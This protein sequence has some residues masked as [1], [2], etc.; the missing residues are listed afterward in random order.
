MHIPPRRAVFPSPHAFS[1][2]AVTDEDLALL[3]ARADRLNADVLKE[4]NQIPPASSGIPMTS[5][6]TAF[7]MWDTTRWTPWY[8]EWLF[9]RDMHK[10]ASSRFFAEARVEFDHHQSMFEIH[11]TDFIGMGGDTPLAPAE[12][13]ELP[14][15]APPPPPDKPWYQDITD[16]M[17]QHMMTTTLIAG[18]GLLAYW[19]FTQ[20]R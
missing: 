10:D 13:P 17:S 3:S 1:V 16:T 5:K 15:P 14:A 12:I 20:R 8:A 9:W 2:L 7:V 6:Q 18:A 4:R 19:H 11:L